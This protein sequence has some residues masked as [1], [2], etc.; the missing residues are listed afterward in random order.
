[1]HRPIFRMTANQ[2]KVDKSSSFMIRNAWNVNGNMV[3]SHQEVPKSVSTNKI[4]KNFLKHIKNL[5]YIKNL[6]PSSNG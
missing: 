4:E 2:L 6:L 5:K 1:M 3:E